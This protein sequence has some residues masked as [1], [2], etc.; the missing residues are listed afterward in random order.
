MAL[1]YREI[2]DSFV[3]K[4]LVVLGMNDKDAESARAWVEKEGLPFVVLLDVDRTVGT[5]YGMS[6]PSAERYVANAAEG[7][8]PAVVIDEL[9]FISAW[10]PDINT[11]EK[12]RELIQSL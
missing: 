11:A 10:E 8:R 6:D 2:S 9:G 5:A 7:R 4:N 12:I 3:E 1:G